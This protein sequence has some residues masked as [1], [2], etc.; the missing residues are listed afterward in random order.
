MNIFDWLNK[1]SYNKRD[2]NEFTPEQQAA[3]DPYMIHRFVSMK[4]DYVELVSDIQQLIGHLPKKNIY[5]LW[6]SVIPKKKTFFRYIKSKKTLPNKLLIILANYW[7]ISTR[8]VI[9]NYHLL[10]EDYIKGLLFE[11][12]IDGRKHKTYLK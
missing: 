11:L 6:C 4:Q 12:G 3:F 7:K 1:I 5:N 8:E 10:S 9:D 2:W